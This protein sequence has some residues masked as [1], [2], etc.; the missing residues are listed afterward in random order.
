MPLTDILVHMD[1]GKTCASRLEAAVQLALKH[2]AHLT[3]LYAM[4]S[5]DVPGYVDVQLPAD[6]IKIRNDRLV[7]AAEAVEATFTSATKRAGVTSEWR[8]LK[9][10]AADLIIDHGH[11]AD[12]IIV[13]Q[14]DPDTVMGPALDEIPDQV[15]MASGR[16]VLVIPRHFSGAEIGSKVMVGWDRGQQATRAIHDALPLLQKADAVSVL[17]VSQNAEHGQTGKLPAA[18]IAHHLARHE[19]QVEADHIT[20]SDMDVGDQL[21]SRAADMGADLLV[22][23]AYGHARWR[24]LVLGGVTRQLLDSMPVPV[25]MS[26]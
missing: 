2:Q 20:N 3:G 21:L 10:Y 8:C 16:P 18:D 23:G 1:D 6:L 9:G 22:T 24:E 5:P 12:L 25:L 13:S 19:V 4:P 15:I 17:I 26:H 11:Y 14:H 7:A